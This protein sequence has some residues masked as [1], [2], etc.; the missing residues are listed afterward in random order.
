VLTRRQHF[1]M[2]ILRQSAHRNGRTCLPKRSHPFIVVGLINADNCAYHVDKPGVK[3]HDWNSTAV[4]NSF[5]SFFF[6]V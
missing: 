1:Y 4:N 5:I 3:F 6:F 2:Y